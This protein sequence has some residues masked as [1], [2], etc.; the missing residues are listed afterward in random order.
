MLADM[1]PGITYVYI[2]SFQVENLDGRI[3]S[4]HVAIEFVAVLVPLH[5]VQCIALHLVVALESNRVILD[6]V[7]RYSYLRQLDSEGC[8]CGIGRTGNC[9]HMR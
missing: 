7:L 6:G 8:F 9:V 2:Y 5:G 3:I 4:W 1:E